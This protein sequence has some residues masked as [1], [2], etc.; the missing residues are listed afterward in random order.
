MNLSLPIRSLSPRAMKGAAI[1]LAG[2]IL[3]LLLAV[4]PFLWYSSMRE[5]AVAQA[6]ERDRVKARVLA[7][8]DARG[9]MLTEGD[10]PQTMFLPGTTAGTTLAAFQT[11]VSDV[12]VASGISVLRMQPL[13]GGE[14]EGLSA[15]RLAVDAAG[16]ME[17]LQRFLAGIESSLPVVTV[18]GF[19]IVPRA[20]AGP[21][22]QPFASD[23]LAIS[24]TLEAY[25]WRGAP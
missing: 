4:L 12:A 14:G 13:P 2:A 19:G 1:L 7:R 15:Y 3:L 17:Q 20:A 10:Q 5:Q 6:A 21:E 22:R 24:L 9:R 18:A 23:D 25:A 8:A 11:M 16:S